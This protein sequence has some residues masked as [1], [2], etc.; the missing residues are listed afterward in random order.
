MV[1]KMEDKKI[2]VINDHC[3]SRIKPKLIRDVKTEAVL[4]FARTA[5]ERFFNKLEND[6]AELLLGSKE[7]TRYIYGSLK[8]LL[9][10]LQKH[11]VN[12]EYL[13]E[14]IQNAKKYP[15]SL[16]LRQ[17][18]KYEEPLINY[19]D[20]MA[21]R[22]EYHF[23]Q[24]TAAIPEFIVICV[25]CNWFLENE[26]PTTIYPFIE[27]Y[28][29]LKLIEKFELYTKNETDDKR[30]LVSRMQM[31]SIDVVETLKKTKYKFNKERTSKRKKRK[32]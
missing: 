2:L 30:K 28:D 16:E 19:Y 1:K 29:F 24:K 23:P 20:A 18:A 5:L 9:K 10:E 13:I 12:V 3:E 14:L 15:G 31:V 6:N 4:V 17:L 27:K 26:T 32:A 7:D 11:V 8:E 25:L 22:M 21:K